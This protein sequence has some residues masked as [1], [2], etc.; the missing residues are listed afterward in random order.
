MALVKLNLGCGDKILPGYVN[1]D[2]AESRSGK[3]PDVLCD[4]HRLTPFE[5]NSADEILSVHVV[6]HFWRW[7]VVEVLKE[8]VRVLKPGG[9]MIVECPN[10][11]SACEAFLADPERRA[12]GGPDGRSTMWVFYGDP[13]WCD[14]LMVHRWGYTPQSLSALMAEVGLVNIRQELAQ[15]KQREPRDMRVVGEKPS[16][17]GAGPRT[18]W[19]ISL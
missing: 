17:P 2:V 12:S 13:S 7:E 4:L 3:R 1:V 10:L 19:K 14:P 18:F 8:W 5:D 6:E 11:K 15:Y 9:L 16:N